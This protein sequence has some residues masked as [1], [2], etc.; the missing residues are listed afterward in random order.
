MSKTNKLS[1]LGLC[2]TCLCTVSNFHAQEINDSLSM[3]VTFV[4]EREMVVKDAIK[5]QSWPEPRRLDG[6]N[7]D[8]SYKLLSK[9]LNVMP[10]WTHVEP[11]RL[12]VDAPLARL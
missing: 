4:G 5:L 2:L 3:D 8:F 10:E 6:G 7:R 11:V 9:R 1:A 12:K